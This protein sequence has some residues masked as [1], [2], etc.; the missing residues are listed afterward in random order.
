M[1]RNVL[2]AL[3]ALAL[4]LVGAACQMELPGSTPALERGRQALEAK[5]Y[6]Q[7]IQALDE[8]IGAD[9][10]NAEAYYLRAS[11]YYGRYNDAYTA[12]DSQADGE[13]F[14]RAVSDFTSD[15]GSTT[16]MQKPTTTA[17]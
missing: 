2:L 7:A 15:P 16:A 10:Q 9:A 5:E 11:A 17:A 4:W 6:D 13:D 8:A 14:W 3:A 12:G 1:N